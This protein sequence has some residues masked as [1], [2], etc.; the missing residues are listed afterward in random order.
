M[1]R[2]LKVLVVLVILVGAV[3]ALTYRWALER[4]GEQPLVFVNLPARVEVRPGMGL[5][6]VGGALRAAGAQA[7]DWL[8]KLAARLRDDAHRLQVGI[9][10]VRE[11][12]TLRELLDRMV[13]GDVLMAEIRFIEGWRFAQLRATVR[14]H[15]ELRHETDSLDDRALLQRLGIER[16]HPEG[17]FFPS[18]YRFPAGSSD[19]DIYRMSHD[20]LRKL[21][22]EAWAGREEGLPLATPYEALVLASVVEKETGVEADRPQ[23]AGV[24]VNRLRRGM[25][26]QSDPTTIYGLGDAFDGDLRRVHLRSDTP[27]NTY[28]RHGLPP[29][30]IALVSRASLRAVLH[31]AS[32]DALYFVARGDGSSQFSA[33]LGEHNSAVRR[34]QL[35][36]PK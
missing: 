31:P 12:Q 17:L 26:L 15:P 33:T 18:T 11:P 20:A 1:R 16:D 6:Q 24:F 7:P 2:T 28:T 35:G 29:T 5:R 8:F 4:Y 23:I 34:Y 30:P 3:A 22:D 13:A 25:M 36:R 9:Y 27:Y 19:L 21:L 14:A 32:T 10:E